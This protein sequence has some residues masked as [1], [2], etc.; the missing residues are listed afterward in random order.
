MRLAAIR[1]EKGVSQ[2]V[3]ACH[4]KVDRSTIAKWESGASMPTAD[5]LV[6][7]AKFL[8]CSVDELLRDEKE[9]EAD[10]H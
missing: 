4:L 6:P 10:E 2:E 5:K 1:K 8:D 7:L 9:G 3:I